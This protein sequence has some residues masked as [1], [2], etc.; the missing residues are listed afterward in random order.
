MLMKGL[1]SRKDREQQKLLYRSEF[2]DL[3]DDEEDEADTQEIA[4]EELAKMSEE[5][6]K[7][8]AELMLRRQEKLKIDYFKRREFEEC[9]RMKRA[10]RRAK[11][12]NMAVNVSNS[13]GFSSYKPIDSN[14]QINDQIIG[15]N[16]NSMDVVNKKRRTSLVPKHYEGKPVRQNVAATI[17]RSYSIQDQPSSINI[18]TNSS[19]NFPLKRSTSAYK[20]TIDVAELAGGYGMGMAVTNSRRNINT[21]SQGIFSMVTGSKNTSTNSQGV[22]DKFKRSFS[23]I[24]RK[25]GFN[26]LTSTGVN[27]VSQQFVFLGEDTNTNNSQTMSASNTNSNNGK[28]SIQRSVSSQDQTGPGMGMSRNTSALFNKLGNRSQM[29]KR[30]VTVMSSGN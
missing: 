23:G 29:L 22:E 6:R 9:T 14:S 7:K 17:S 25:R 20:G 4:A 28:L 16:L 1:S 15:V 18:N 30:S 12:S 24:N 21:Q 19:G 13:Q 27:I 10:L 5:E 8:E 2:D 26:S 3:D 11:E